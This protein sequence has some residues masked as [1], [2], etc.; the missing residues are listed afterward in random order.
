MLA[1]ALSRGGRGFAPA[2]VLS[3]R[4]SSFMASYQAHVEERVAEGVPLPLDAARTAELVALLE[5]PPEGEEQQLI[6]MLVCCLQEKVSMPPCG[7]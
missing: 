1:R 7:G 5:Q 4:I 3:R 6:A 2:S